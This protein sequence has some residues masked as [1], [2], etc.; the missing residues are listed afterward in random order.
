MIIA[1]FSGGKDSMY[2][3][4]KA[5]EMNIYIDKLLF[6]KPSFQHPSPHEFN[7][8]IVI[9]LAKD[10]RLPIYF[11]KLNRGSEIE[12]LASK[13]IELKASAL[14]AG[15]GLLREHLEWY[16]R[17]CR[18]AGIDLIEPLFRFK[19][20]K[21]LLEMIENGLEWTIIAVKN[22]PERFLGLRICSK[23]VL[24]FLKFCKSNEID[25]LGEY[26][27]Y[28]TIVNKSPLIRDRS[29]EIVK[30]VSKGDYEKIA[31]IKE[32]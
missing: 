17:V 1:L 15:D 13:L 27:E 28:H 11:V 9:E 4:I 32:V 23:N 5:I 25:P 26:G 21:L 7:I 14:I 10:M 6:I 20:D 16:E 19:T 2:S 24:E 30:I 18:R 29:Y 3:I 8:R 31:I 12:D 22:L